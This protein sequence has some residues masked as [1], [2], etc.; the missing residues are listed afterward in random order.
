MK[1][2]LRILGGLAVLVLLLVVV[3]FALPRRYRVERSIVINARPETVF[4]QFGDLRAWKNWGAWQERDPNMKMTFSDQ[5][6][7][8]GAW[9]AWESASEGN[10]KMTI[11]HYEPAKHAAYDLEFPEMGMS[12]KG[13][14][15]LQPA[16]GG[17]KVV[18]ADAGDLGMNPMSRWFGLFLDKMI[19]PD[20]EHGLAKMKAL[21][22]AAPR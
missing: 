9:S 15:T 22:E 8:V 7:G 13:S 3:A 19:G 14:M 21:A 11:T 1:T 5:S 18:W 12:S 6:S 17:V 10:G 16:E 20:F 4:A 2:L